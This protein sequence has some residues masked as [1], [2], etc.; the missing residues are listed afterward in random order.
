[1]FGEVDLA[2]IDSE[3]E[4]HLGNRPLA[5]HQQFKDL[6]VFWLH[7]GFHFIEGGGKKVST[8]FLFPERFDLFGTGRVDHEGDLG[9]RRRGLGR[10]VG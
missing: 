3:S 4:R 1:M 8:P 9:L 10:V 6:E 7:P 2:Q 5:H